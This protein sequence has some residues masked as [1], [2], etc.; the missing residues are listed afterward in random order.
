MLGDFL[1]AETIWLARVYVLVFIELASRCVHLVGYR[2][3][4]APRVVSAD[5]PAVVEVDETLETN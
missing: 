4:R 2:G 1:T 3:I 5:S